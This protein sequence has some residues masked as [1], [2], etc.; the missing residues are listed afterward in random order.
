MDRAHKSP[1]DLPEHL[2]PGFNSHDGGFAFAGFRLEPGGALFRGHTPIHLPPK[3]L[4]ALR[5]LLARASQI[6]TPLELRHALWGQV[7]VSADSVPRCLSSLRAHLEPDDCIQTVYKRGYRLKANVQLLGAAPVSPVAR[8]AIAPFAT[9]YG[10]PEYLGAAVAEQT[11]AGLTRARDS[12]VSL[13]AQDSVFTLARRGLM[14]QEIGAALKADFVLTGTLRA[15]PSLFRLRVEM[16]RVRD[17][18][19]VWMEDVLVERDR[20]AG[21]ETELASR[22]NLRLNA[23]FPLG[24]PAP[25]EAQAASLSISAASAPEDEDR[26]PRREAYNIFQ[27]AH[28]HWQSFER[29]QMQDAVQHLLRAIELDPSLTGARIDLINLCVEQALDGFMPPAVA[30]A[31]A[32]RAADHVSDPEGHPEAMLP[33]LGW[34]SFHFDRDLPAALHAFA[35]SANLPHDQWVTRARTMFAL[36]RRRFDEAIELLRRAIEL[37]PFSSWLHGRMAWALHLAGRAAESVEQTRKALALFPDQTGPDLYGVIVLAFNGEPERAAALAEELE[38]RLPY[39]D[40]AAAVHAYALACGGKTG[41]ARAVLERLEWLGRE[42][43]VVSAFTAA[44]YVALGEPDAALAQLRASMNDRCPWFFQ[45]L[46][47][48]RLKPLHG[49]PEFEQMRSLLDAMEAEAGE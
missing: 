39:F 18:V 28:H 20:T 3:E 16:I 21:L 42:R 44:A 9:E 30:A 15:L 38:R 17:A 6:V 37:D 47:D 27:R 14:A 31:F 40:V 45:T 29:H 8:L 41:E 4:A 22:L 24:R 32:R 25:A 19:Q 10:V 1:A 26:L 5:L 34:I 13:L 43:Y 23:T 11:A 7:H 12:A 46:A 49:R 33:S 35:L 2:S 48:P 36:S